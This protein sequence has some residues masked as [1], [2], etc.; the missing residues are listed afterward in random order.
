VCD[1]CGRERRL[2]RLYGRGEDHVNRC[3]DC[4]RY[5]FGGAQTGGTSPQRDPLR[6][7]PATAPRVPRRGVHR[8]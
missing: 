4:L 3:A 2:Y 1:A 7:C 5:A 8:A 6:S